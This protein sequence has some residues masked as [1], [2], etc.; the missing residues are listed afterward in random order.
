MAGGIGDKGD[1]GDKGDKGDKGEQGDRGEKGDKGDKGDSGGTNI[2]VVQSYD[3]LNC[4]AN[5]TLVSVFCPA[6]GTADGAKCPSTPA[7]GLCM[8]KP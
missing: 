4:D 8:R 6:G 7:I 3:A 5:E 2:R 1:R